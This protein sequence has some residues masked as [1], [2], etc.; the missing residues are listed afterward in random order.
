MTPSGP[1]AAPPAETSVLAEIA[2]AIN[3]EASGST[4]VQRTAE[5]LRRHL[6][7]PLGIW[8][9]ESDPARVKLEGISF[10][11]R[12]PAEIVR[13]ITERYGS[14]PV[15]ADLPGTRAMRQRRT[16]KLT[17]EDGDLAAE[18]RELLERLDAAA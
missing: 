16:L 9:R 14:I 13:S 12:F 10:P 6:D 11:E 15:T 7:T 1:G 18:E 2:R 5:A 8:L 4:A 17:R 3:H